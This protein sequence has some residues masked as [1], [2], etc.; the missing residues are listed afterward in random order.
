MGNSLMQYRMVTGMHSL[1]L[2]AREYREC[3]KGKFWSSLVLLFYMEAIYLPV[4]KTLVHRFELMKINRLWLT[5]IYLYRFYIPDLIRLA[6]D[7]ETNPGPNIGYVNP[8]KTLP[9]PCVFTPNNERSQ[10]FMCSVMNLPLVVQH[11]VKP[12]KKL[13]KPSKLSQRILNDGNCLFRAFSYVITGRQVYHT[14][15]REQIINHM[16]HIEHFLLPHMKTSLD[17]YLATRR[18]HMARNGVWGTDIEIL[19]AASLLSTDVFVYTKIGDTYKWQQFSRTMLDGKK[20]ENDC[21]IYLN[22]SNGIH[23][24]VVLDVNADD[25]TESN[26]QTSLSDDIHNFEA[27]KKSQLNDELTNVV[28]KKAKSKYYHTSIAY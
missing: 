25:S 16:R 6:N 28:S 9:T 17:S 10:S 15:V 8:E 3:F 20:P 13:G 27:K 23:Y 5:Q 21:S 19:S 2:K 24:D 22:H 26:S 4:L 1:Y 7:V 18:S 14:K 12:S 11:A